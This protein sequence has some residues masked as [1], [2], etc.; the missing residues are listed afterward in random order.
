MGIILG[1][2]AILAIFPVYIFQ[3][4]YIYIQNTPILIC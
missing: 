2:A 1:E 4:K 3:G